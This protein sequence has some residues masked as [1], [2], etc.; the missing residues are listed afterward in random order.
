MDD[1]LAP[2]TDAVI[3][4]AISENAG[5]AARPMRAD[6]VKNRALILVAAE[7]IFAAEGVTVP[8]DDVAKRAGV[9]VGTLYRHFPTKEA[10]F[11]AIVIA[12]LERLLA[13]AEDYA[14]SDNCGEAFFAFLRELAEQA[15]AKRDL[16]DALG[17]AGIDFKS[18]CAEILDEMLASVDALL[19]RAVRA[20][21]VRKDVSAQEVVNLVT[22]A[23]H[24]GGHTD[25]D[26]TTILHMIDVVIDGLQP[27]TSTPTH[28][29]HNV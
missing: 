24:A 11:E 10:L 9:G 29:S 5:V 17:S 3:D 15:S 2:A 23:C 16:I 4:D 19:Q 1:E 18:S 7:E 26:I 27:R 20:G 28:T 13:T 8:I 21:A 12:R 25:S 22:G 6:A 14:R